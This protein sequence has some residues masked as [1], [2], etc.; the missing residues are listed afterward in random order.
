M[1]NSFLFW[2]LFN[3]RFSGM[4]FSDNLPK[5]QKQ[6]QGSVYEFNFK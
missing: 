1:K 6:E 4:S 3:T 5:M 2:K